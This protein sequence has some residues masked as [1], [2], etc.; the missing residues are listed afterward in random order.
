ME[1]G[2]SLHKRRK[3]EHNQKWNGLPWGGSR[4]LYCVDTEP[5]KETAL[6][7]PPAVGEVGVASGPAEGTWGHGACT[8]LSR[9]RSGMTGRQGQ[10]KQCVCSAISQGGLNTEGSTRRASG[11]GA[12]NAII[13]K[14]ICDGH[15][16]RRRR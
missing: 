6:H 11:A 14:G 16:N 10:S 9:S 12:A 13:R 3:S 4:E 1:V 7:L 5:R 2:E 8:P 15:H